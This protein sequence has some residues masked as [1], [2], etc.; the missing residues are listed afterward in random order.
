MQIE[1]FSP[2]L[3]CGGE[4]ERS[5]HFSRVDEV[6]GL[7]GRGYL[8]SPSHF[9]PTIMLSVRCESSYFIDKA[10]GTREGDKPRPQSW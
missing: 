8:T 3:P 1:E 4:G 10:T 2:D 5:C 7:Y 9:T 6:L